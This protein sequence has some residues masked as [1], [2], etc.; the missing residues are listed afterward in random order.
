MVYNEL[1][2]ECCKGCIHHKM[3]ICDADE[4]ASACRLLRKWCDQDDEN[5]KHKEV[6]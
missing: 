2:V 5:C 3:R 6:K 4:Y 1:I